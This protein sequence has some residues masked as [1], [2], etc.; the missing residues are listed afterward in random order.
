MRL[1]VKNNNNG[2][3]LNIPEVIKNISDIDLLFNVYDKLGQYEDLEEQGNLIKIPYPIGTVLSTRKNG[4]WKNDKV[5][6]YIIDNEGLK[7]ILLLDY[8]EDNVHLSVPIPVERLN[9]EWV[10]TPTHDSQKETELKLDNTL[11][12]DIKELESYNNFEV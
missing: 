7:V 6:H 8:G 11:E 10:L 12:D 5:H 9:K 1:T 3:S 4:E 2:Y